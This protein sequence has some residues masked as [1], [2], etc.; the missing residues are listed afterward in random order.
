MEKVKQAIL[1]L[2]SFFKSDLD[3]EIEN[4][5]QCLGIMQLAQER[6]IKIDQKDYNALLQDAALLKA[7]SV[8]DGFASTKN[9][10]G[11][12]FLTTGAIA[13]AVI[14]SVLYF[15][16]APTA[17]WVCGTF[18]ALAPGAFFASKNFAEGAVLRKQ[19]RNLKNRSQQKFIDENLHDKDVLFD[20]AAHILVAKNEYL[21][22]VENH[23]P[24]FEDCDDNHFT[25]AA[26]DFI[27]YCDKVE[28]IAYKKEEREL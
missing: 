22:K 25:E 6:N 2:K 21:D 10:R 11:I 27:A 18:A 13:S 24:I 1:K 17:G 19:S 23:A 26:A 12:I 14:G 20:A 3:K 28:D 9:H 16:G 15:T 5:S 8:I 4:V 7:R